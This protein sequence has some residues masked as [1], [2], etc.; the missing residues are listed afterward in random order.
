MAALN[1]QT[2]QQAAANPASPTLIYHRRPSTGAG[3]ISPDLM[4]PAVVHLGLGGFHRAHQAMVFDE[5]IARGD[6][7]WGVCA[8]GMRSDT[9][10]NQLQAQDHLYLVR[11][12]DAKGSQ[13]HAP[14]AIVKSLVAATQREAVIEQIASPHTRWLTLTVTEKAY[15]AELAK[16]VVDG[17]RKRMAAGLG[18]L[19]IASCDNLPDNG[20]VLR[21]LC[22][23]VAQDGG[24][25]SA[26]GDASH[27]HWIETECRFPV[28]MVD[29]IVP[30]PSDEIRQAACQ[31]LGLDDPTALGV[32]AFWEWVIEE[33]FVDPSDANALRSVG[34]VV[35]NDV[36]GFEQAKL[37]MLNGSHTVLAAAGAVL[38][39]RFIRQVIARPAMKQFVHGF[40]TQASGPLVGRPHWQAYRDALVARFGNPMLDHACLQVYSDSSQ[41]I[42]V[43][44][45]PVAERLLAGHQPVGLDSVGL[46]SVGLHSVG[47]HY[48]AMA[49]AIFIRSL[50]PRTETGTAFEFKDPLAGELQGLARDQVQDPARAVKGLLDSEP[51]AR[52]LGGKLVANADF[53]Q[54]TTQYLVRIH[55]VGLEVAVQ[56]F[57]S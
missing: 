7:R 2:V 24:S 10:T 49:A 26:V 21:D 56:D 28:S 29:R 32:E 35:T 41:K 47:L 46:N 36:A 52:L 37:W 38:G 27:K 48:L 33:A 11:V 43:R 22:L 14:S 20:R 51:G 15:T 1:Q 55:A 6:K 34:V 25:D 45:A 42:P 12:S 9:L 31:D 50:L 13:W 17:L 40:M 30:A 53:V 18:G 39:D 44:W 54:A 57:C 5:L 4:P 8:V 19:T 16:L 3:E 23:T